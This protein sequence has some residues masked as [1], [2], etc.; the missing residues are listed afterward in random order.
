MKK[1]E[2]LEKYRN[3]LEQ[4][5]R[6]KEILS[7]EEI[8]AIN[9][10]LQY[11][12]PEEINGQDIQNEHINFMVS[13]S[14]TD[15]DK[16]KHLYSESEYNKVKKTINGIPTSKKIDSRVVIFNP[17]IMPGVK[18]IYSENGLLIKKIDSAI[19]LVRTEYGPKLVR[20]DRLSISDSVKKV[21]QE[22]LYIN[23][24]D[25]NIMKSAVVVERLLS[26]KKNKKE[27]LNLNQ[28][29]MFALWNYT[30]QNPKKEKSIESWVNERLEKKMP[31]SKD[32]YIAINK[33]WKLIDSKFETEYNDKEYKRVKMMKF[34]N[35]YR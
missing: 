23:E 8:L 6:I 28:E 34:N 32:S 26:K 4:Y 33:N 10:I 14:Q 31:L 15:N 9:A 35:N 17:V 30:K 16:R 5:P 27:E 29:A 19:E 3:A 18:H 24:S 22:E 2:I 13:L 7:I 21:N 11:K 20:T 1:K 12:E 25:L